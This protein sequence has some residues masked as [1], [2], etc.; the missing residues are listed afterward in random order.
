MILRE[1]TEVNVRKRQRQER[2]SGE[3]MGEA[4]GGSK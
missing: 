1:I 3:S 2:N 4:S